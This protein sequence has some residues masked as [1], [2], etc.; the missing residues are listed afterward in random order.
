VGLLAAA[1]AS[2]EAVETRLRVHVYPFPGDKELGAIRPS[3]VQ[4][5][6]RGRQHECAPRYVRVMLVNLSTILSSAVEDGKIVRNPC[7][8]SLV[9]A[10]RIEQQGIV[11]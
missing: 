3:T 8:A 4:V 10:P 5:W 1:I 6:L 7:D 2:R 9:R 11:P